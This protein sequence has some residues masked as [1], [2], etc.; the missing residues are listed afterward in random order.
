MV[1]GVSF[2]IDPV[3]VKNRD[4]EFKKSFIF[5]VE[6]SGVH[7]FP[8]CLTQNRKQPQKGGDFGRQRFKRL[9]KGRRGSKNIFY[10]QSS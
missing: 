3:I 5:E 6:T 8:P 10:D 9:K 7:D 2:L 4:K 1:R